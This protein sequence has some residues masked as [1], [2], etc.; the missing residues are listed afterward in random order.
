[1]SRPIDAY[2]QS[3]AEL[4]QQSPPPP[5]T[6]PAAE[7][8]A[9]PEGVNP[10]VQA[11]VDDVIDPAATAEQRT[12]AYEDVQ[13][14]YDAAASGGDFT[15]I[16]PATLRVNAI[17]TLTDAGIPTRFRPEVVAAVDQ[18]IHAYDTS[19]NGVHLPG[20]TPEQVLAAYQQVED[21]VDGVGGLGDAGITA[22]AL[23]A[24]TEQLLRE[25]AVPTVATAAADYVGDAL[26]GFDDMSDEEQIAALVEAS[27][28]L[29]RMTADVDPETAAIIAEQALRPIEDRIGDI[30][31]AGVMV[32]GMLAPAWTS[33]ATVADRVAGTA[34]GDAI[35]NRLADALYESGGGPGNF[36]LLA[37][38]RE[39]GV[40]LGLFLRMAEVA[41]AR[42]G[43]GATDVFMREV[44]TA[45]DDFVGNGVQP[46]IDAY[47]EHTAELNWLLQN[48]GPGATPEML[49]Q[50]TQAYID[51][52]PGWQERH[53]ELQAEVARQGGL[54]LQQIEA[55]RNL[56]PGLREEYGDD[57]EAQIKELLEDPET[58]FAI[59]T[60]AGTNP[61][62][63]A[64]LDLPD[65][66]DFAGTLGL[67]DSGLNVVK[68]LATAHVQHNVLGSLANL[69]PSDPS[70]LANARA[71]IATLRNPSI[72]TAL[73]IDP[74]Q[75]DQ[76][77]TAVDELQRTLPQAGE[78][79]SQ[80]DVEARLARLNTQLDQL[81]AFHNSQ[82]LGQVF[83]GIGVAAGVASLWGATSGFIDDPSLEGAV[84]TLAG[85]AGLSTAVGDL[86]T[87]LGAIPETSV[88]ARF[89]ASTT[90]GKVLGTVG[91]GLGLVG[92][93]DSLSEGDLAQA[94][95]GAV[96]VG[97]G[98]LALFGTASWAGPVGVVIGFAAA[99][100]SFGLSIFRANEAEGELED[101]SRPFLESL[102]FD[103][104]AADILSDFSGEGYSSVGLLMRY[105]ESRGLTAVETVAWINDIPGEELGRLRDILNYVADDIDGKYADFPATTSDDA[106]FNDEEYA[107]VARDNPGHLVLGELPPESAA[108]LDIA[109]EVLGITVPE[110]AEVPGGGLQAHE[111]A[112]GHL[113]E[114]HVGKSEAELIERLRRENISA[115]SSFRE[116]GE[117]E[118]F[119]AETLT[120]NQEQIDAWLDGEGGNRL[121]VNATFD[122]STG[123][124]VQRGDTEAEDVFSVRLVLERSDALD[125]GYRIV[126]GYPTAP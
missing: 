24:R 14:Y 66:V 94:G 42:Y 126:T 124:S 76:L 6:T 81:S 108:Q 111:D 33:L 9:V 122:A 112:G 121:V 115:S 104:E 95:I 103:E 11:A 32:D 45:L 120:E 92:V 114:R 64:E 125:V 84:Q 43:E 80:A 39:Q 85:A 60:A 49:Q 29:E 16:D 88:W 116:L 28:R 75:L 40:G 58:G 118:Y 107:Q 90:F 91:L 117:A 61:E 70:A 50:A 47:S 41:D 5:A 7:E 54:L 83:R 20:A 96:G 18:T 109:L 78:T 74:S 44:N 69:D 89:S 48:L 99:A 105:G 77:D 1:M 38:L 97:G 57:A 53:D 8:A 2:R 15:G 106:R 25:N 59:A 71:Q 93:V 101:A 65:M 30:E 22:E 26:D 86:A 23:P 36:N 87:G 56:P 17:R 31:V 10:E 68:A 110:P 51:A 82:P 98:A 4:P 67:T 102:G 46:A 13:Q 37:P 19:I 3:P 52:N 63:I 119:V 55:L 100:A 34:R 35:V 21:Y 113:I 62:S 123:I 12:A 72:A 27:E 73:G 79:L